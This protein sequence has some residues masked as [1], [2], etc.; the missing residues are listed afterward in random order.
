MTN[1]PSS[2]KQTIDDRTIKTV[3]NKTVLGFVGLGPNNVT[4]NTKADDLYI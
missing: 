2:N 4:L 1:S 3:K